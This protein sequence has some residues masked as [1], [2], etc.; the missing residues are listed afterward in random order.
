MSRLVIDKETGV[1]QKIRVT[2]AV[3][4]YAYLTSPRPEGSLKEGTYGT[5]LI[6]RDEETI[7]LVK[8]Y[9]K[10]VAQHA[11]TN[12]WR[13]QPKELG[14]PYALGDEENEREAGALVFKTSAPKFQPTLL[15]RNPKTGR[16]HQLEE[17]EK[18]E[19]Y[20]GMLVDADVVLKPWAVGGKFGVTA[21]VNAV[22]KVG[23]GEPFAARVN[24]EDSFSIDTD[25]NA[26][27]EDTFDEV[28]EEEVVGVNTLD[29]LL[30]D[31]TATANKVVAAGKAAPKTTTKAKTAAP[32]EKPAVTLDDLLA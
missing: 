16:A 13:V 1:I 10:Q 19:Y 26:E 14:L 5:E 31:A 29:D 18:D 6:I 2:N 22:C 27:D 3:A 17:D 4:S 23:D 20:S 25:F 11:I 7:A 30:G 24:Y 15:I 21:Y 32:K 9:T 8:Q 12:V 28:Q